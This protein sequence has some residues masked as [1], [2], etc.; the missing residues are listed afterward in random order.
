MAEF[1]EECRI[2]TNEVLSELTKEFGPNVL[3]LGMRF[4]MNSGS[5]TGG[6][7]RGLKSRFELF[8]DTINTASRMESTGVKDKIQ[9][10][11]E[12]ADELRM[13]GYESWLRPRED[14]VL[15][16]GKGY[17]QTYWLEINKDDPCSDHQDYDFESREGQSSLADQTYSGSRY[18]DND[19]VDLNNE[20]ED[21]DNNEGGAETVEDRGYISEMTNKQS[22]FYN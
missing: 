21:D 13:K 2:K 16:K 1:A 22:S 3:K 18:M 20:I 14:H 7:L 8:G 17:M 5:V 11:E 15:A 10:S 19:D 6:V 4:G 9:V 12:T